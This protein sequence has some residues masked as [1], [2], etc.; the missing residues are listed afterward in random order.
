MKMCRSCYDLQKASGGYISPD[1]KRIDDAKECMIHPTL[2]NWRVLR[3]L[4]TI[5]CWTLEHEG[6]RHPNAKGVNLVLEDGKIH[7]RTA[8]AILFDYEAPFIDLLVNQGYLIQHDETPISVSITRK[9]D[10]F[11]RMKTENA[12]VAIKI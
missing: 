11:I 1:D 9:G 7:R 12:E 5:K 4:K 8:Q 2:D 10:D 3:T 6:Y